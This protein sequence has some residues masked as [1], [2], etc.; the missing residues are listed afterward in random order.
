M[1]FILVILGFI[2]ARR[3]QD[4]PGFF[5]LPP[6]YLRRTFGNSRIQFA[7]PYRPGATRFAS[8]LPTIPM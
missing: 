7:S 8:R 1:V 3:S 4:A 6:P 2:L 5:I